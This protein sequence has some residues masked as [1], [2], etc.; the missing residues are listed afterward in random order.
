MWIIIL[1]ED[2]V[3]VGVKDCDRFSET[4]DFEIKIIFLC[5][6]VDVVHLRESFREV[7]MAWLDVVGL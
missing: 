6:F 1:N 2:N 3:E 5:L 7:L 4:G